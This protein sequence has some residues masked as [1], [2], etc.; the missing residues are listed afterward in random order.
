[1]VALAAVQSFGGGIDRKLLADFLSVPSESHNNAE[2]NRSID[3]LRTWLEPRGVFCS[4]TTND[5][6]RAWLY[7]ATTPEKSTDYLFVG[8]VDVVPAPK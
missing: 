6:G 1:M 2:I 4:V 8:H 7:A 5:V 3:V